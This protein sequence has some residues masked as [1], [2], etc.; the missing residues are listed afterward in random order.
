[1]FVI[2]VL[3]YFN[4]ICRNY[5]KYESILPYII[6]FRCTKLCPVKEPKELFRNYKNNN[7]LTVNEETRLQNLQV[8]H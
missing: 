2:I 3:I 6:H 1:M 8:L 4:C 5:S 7:I